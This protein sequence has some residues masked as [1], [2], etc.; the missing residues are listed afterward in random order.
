M[1]KTFLGKLAKVTRTSEVISSDQV[2]QK[3]DNLVTLIETEEP[4]HFKFQYVTN[5]RCGLGF[6]YKQYDIT[7]ELD[8]VSRKRDY[9]TCEICGK[10]VGLFTAEEVL[11]QSVI[12]RLGIDTLI[13]GFNLTKGHSVMA[14]VKVS[15]ED[16]QR[17]EK[18]VGH[19][20]TNRNF[21]LL[22]QLGSAKNIVDI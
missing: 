16:K 10:K 1:F 22:T 18:E 8:T 9:T 20:I 7:V 6:D 14:N 4:I 5:L 12:H 2:Q 3:Q 21:K 13:N 17:F 15:D 11:G 19:Q